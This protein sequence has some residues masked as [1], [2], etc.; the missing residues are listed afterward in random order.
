MRLLGRL[1]PLDELNASRRKEMFALYA[2]HYD[3]VTFGQF[4]ED[5][6]A[7]QWVIEVIDPADGSLRG[8]STQCVLNVSVA[9]RVVRALFSGD[10]IVDREFWGDPA[11]SHVWGHLALS[12]IDKYHDEPLYWYLISKGYRTY[13]FLPVF[14]HEFYPRHDV[15]TP[16][17]EAAVLHALG[18]SKFGDTY[19]DSK[20]IIRPR[21]PCQLRDG[22]GEITAARMRD[23]HVR[24]FLDS[25]PAHALGD[26][27]CCLAPLSRE[28]FTAA[29]WRVI[30]VSPATAHKE[31][32]R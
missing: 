30:G 10:T 11:L 3:G 9:G 21:N 29:A 22:L 2:R 8:F 6:A 13:R 18:R 12:L 32:A 28:N 26:E 4:E 24:F 7:K 23:P 20:G 15:P 25:N 14:F 17:A 27:L 31:L 19:D 5:L 16:P 1:T